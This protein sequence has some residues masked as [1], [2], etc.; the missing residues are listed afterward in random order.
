MQRMVHSESGKD[1][2]FEYIDTGENTGDFNMKFDMELVEKAK[3]SGTSYIRVY[4]WKPYAIS[5]GYNQNDDGINIDACKSDGIDVVRRP[6]GGRAVF[7]A[8]E[9][10]YSVVMISDNMS[11]SD[12]YKN[13]SRMLLKA[14][15]EYQP[16]ISQ[17]I[18]FEKASLNISEHYKT[19]Q[20][21]ACFA[22]SALNEIKFTG[23]KLVGSAQSRYGNILLQHGSIMLNT[24]H[25]D[26]IRYIK[27]EKLKESLRRILDEK[28]ISFSEI[29]GE[30]PDTEKIKLCIKNEFLGL[31]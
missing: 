11:I 28:T 16:L 13:I 3:D 27:N 19:S 5:L 6:T 25:K 2:M 23:K 14:L 10:T 20:S 7:H 17:H 24:K 29:L 1:K 12:E 8:E 4:Q 15:A 21:F 31:N 26:I 22:A 9:L 18:S 30:P